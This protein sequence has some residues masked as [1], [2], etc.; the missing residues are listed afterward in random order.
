MKTVAVSMVSILLLTLLPGARMA[1]AEKGSGDIGQER[2]ER[3]VQGLQVEGSKDHKA[4]SKQKKERKLRS[5]MTN[6]R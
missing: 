2:Q 4:G 6:E 5:E 1:L 3:Q